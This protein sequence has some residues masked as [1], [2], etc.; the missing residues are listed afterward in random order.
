MDVSDI[1][2]TDLED[3][4]IAPIVLKEY[5]EQVTKRIK[6]DKYMRIL[7]IYANSIFQDFENFL[8]TEVDLVEDDIRLVLDEYNSSSIT[9]EFEPGIYTLKDISKA[10]F[11]IRQPEYELYSNPVDI[12]YDDITMK[13]KLVVRPGIIAIRFDEK[14]FF[15][16]ARDFTPHWDYKHYNEY[17]SQK[18]VNLSITNEIHFKCD[19]IDGSVVN[20]LRQPMLYSFV[21]NKK[22]WFQSFL[23][24]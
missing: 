24:H 20:R 9:Y 13:N 10:L 17:I 16:T 4:I 12:E 1:T 18:I 15:S 19:V 5:R 14:W 6:D 11:N 22:T 2:A 7:A 8:R 23:R 21:L 3:D